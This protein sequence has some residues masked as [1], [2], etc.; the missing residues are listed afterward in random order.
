MVCSNQR[1]EFTQHNPYIMDIDRENINC[2]SCEG[3]RHLV[4]NCRNRG[5]ETRIGESRRLEYQNEE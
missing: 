2:Y 3:F 4:R 5:T 1:A